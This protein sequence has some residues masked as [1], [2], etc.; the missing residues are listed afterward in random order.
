MAKRGKNYRKVAE[1]VDKSKMYG[2][3]EGIELAL[4]GGNSPSGDALAELEAAIAL[5]V[6]ARDSLAPLADTGASDEQISGENRDTLVGELLQAVADNNPEALDM[7]G[8]L[9]AG[10]PEDDGSFGP[11]SAARDALDMYDF[12]GAS[13]QLEGLQRGAG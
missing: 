11:L 7:I 4:K 8:Q 1:E 13:Q 10:L 12:A 6:Q 5:T 3:D 9:L 2:L